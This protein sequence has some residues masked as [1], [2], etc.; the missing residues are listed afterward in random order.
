MK[1]KT[2]LFL[3]I[4]LVCSIVIC[5][6]FLPSCRNKNEAVWAAHYVPPANETVAILLA[7]YHHRGGY[8]AIFG[9]RKIAEKRIGYPIEEYAKIFEGR[10]WLIK[11]IDAYKI[12]VKEGEKKEIS[13][14]N[15][16]LHIP[17]SEIPGGGVIFFLTP[18]RIY[19]REIK[20]NK[21]ENTVCDYYMKS[22]L[23]KQ[24]FDELGLTDELGKKELEP[25]YWYV[26][27]KLYIPP[28]N[29]TN[30][31]L[32]YSP[33]D[34]ALFAPTALIGDKKE[35]EKLTGMRIKPEKIIEGRERLEKMMDAFGIAFKEIIEEKRPAPPNYHYHNCGKIIFI[36]QNRDYV[37]EGSDFGECDTYYKY[38]GSGLLKQYFDELGITKELLAGEP[39]KATQN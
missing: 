12:A 5:F 23:L 26:G 20:I 36:T 3:A 9:D 2:N 18:K 16:F 1:K 25:Y 37:I 4:C 27:E 13:N 22:T 32:L 17:G 33:R 11:I 31:I 6:I 14:D 7:S 35:A 21:E 10:E 19:A 15:D 29:E 28:T 34:A 30:A 39:N 38:M 8:F 24:Y